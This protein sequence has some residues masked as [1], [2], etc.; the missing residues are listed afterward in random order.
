M[1]DPANDLLE[2]YSDM[3]TKTVETRL[4]KIPT[5]PDKVITFFDTGGMAEQNLLNSDE[6][7]LKYPTV[8]VRIRGTKNSY[9]DTRELAED[10]YDNLHKLYLENMNEN[11]YKQVIAVGEP[12]WLG[13][14]ENNRP[15]WSINFELMM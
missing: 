7:G 14:D 4:G 3:T 8:Q 12:I 15:E 13:Y 10:V 5:E 6:Q 1:I 9:V 2:Y 11:L